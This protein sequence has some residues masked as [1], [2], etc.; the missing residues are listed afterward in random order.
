MDDYVSKGGGGMGGINE[1][2]QGGKERSFK[3]V[4]LELR[5]NSSFKNQ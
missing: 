2:V 3:E 1:P 4:V 5:T